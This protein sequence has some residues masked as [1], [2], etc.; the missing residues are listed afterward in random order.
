M[1]GTRRDESHHFVEEIMNQYSA[2]GAIGNRGVI[3]LWPLI[4]DY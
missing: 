3:D 2:V 1:Q 4:T